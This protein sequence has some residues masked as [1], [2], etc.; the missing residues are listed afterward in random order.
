LPDVDAPAD[1]SRLS[2]AVL[3][4]S[5]GST[6]RQESEGKFNQTCKQGTP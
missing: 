2:L 4:A 5:F 1:D 3:N 6:Y